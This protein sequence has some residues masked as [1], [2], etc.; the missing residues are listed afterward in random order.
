MDQPVARS[1]HRPISPTVSQLPPLV[2][3]HAACREVF[4]FLRHPTYPQVSYS[5]SNRVTAS[6]PISAAAFTVTNVLSTL[7]ASASGRVRATLS[8]SARVQKSPCASSSVSASFSNR[9]AASVST[10][11][12]GLYIATVSPSLS[13]IASPAM[14]NNAFR[15]VSRLFPLLA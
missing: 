10:S 8:T 7:L 5:A 1:L 14:Y 13:A 6:L 3:C 4:W 9:V 11:V 2:N 12:L 15:R